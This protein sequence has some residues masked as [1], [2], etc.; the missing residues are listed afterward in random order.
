MSDMFSGDIMNVDSLQI[1][2]IF[3]CMNP[4]Y[5]EAV[6]KRALNSQNKVSKEARGLLN[7]A[8][9]EYIRVDGYKNTDR[10]PAL[11]LKKPVLKAVTQSDKLAG[12]VLKVWAESHDALGDV[13]VKHLED[14]AML[15][16]YPDLSGNRFRGTWFCD[17]WARETDKILERHGEFDKD[18]VAL[19]LCYVSGK[20]P[21]SRETKDDI[22]AQSLEYLRSLPPNAPEWEQE[23]PEFVKLLNDI[24]EVKEKQR[25]QAAD[26][27]ATIADIGDAF[28][29]ELAF[30]QRDADAWSAAQL[31][32]DA[33]ISEALQLTTELQSL[34]TEYQSVYGMAPVFSEEQIRRQQ[35]EELEPRVLSIMG[36]IDRLMGGNQGPDDDSPSGI[37]SVYNSDDSTETSTVSDSTERTEVR[38]SSGEA[39]E[40]QPTGEMID[41]GPPDT[42]D[43]GVKSEVENER[44][45]S[46][47]DYTFFLSEN[48]RLNHEVESLQSQLHK[49]QDEIEKLQKEAERWRKYYIEAASKGAATAGE[50]E[51]LSIESV[52]DAVECAKEKYNDKLLFQLNAKSQVKD[53]PFMHPKAVWDALQWLATTYY[54]FRMRGED[55]LPNLDVSIRKACKWWYRGHQSNMTVNKY[56]DWYTTKVGNKIHELKKHIGTGSSKDARY[57]IR[58][59][60]DWDTIQ[61]RVVIGFIGQHQQTDAT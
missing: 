13:V 46:L 47:E 32:P 18:D 17:A 55:N 26:L 43:G 52:N 57:T 50:G 48:Q 2:T 7:S 4:E 3:E 37:E 1:S 28:S 29:A 21:G 11:Y 59:A 30:F 61:E 20:I 35:R 36:R 45:F 5:H 34:L 15:A 31:S 10:A 56:K 53:N 24:R 58:I 6:V 27:D 22:L 49:R 14:L 51:D 40:Q 9:R 42:Q 8:I 44:A 25:S 54:G 23:I 33:D 60:F 16:E 12:A 41:D 39:E 19:M 38:S